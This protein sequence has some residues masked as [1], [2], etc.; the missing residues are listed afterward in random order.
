[1]LANKK[2]RR[3]LLRQRAVSNQKIGSFD[4]SFFYPFC[5]ISHPLL[6]LMLPVT[7]RRNP[8]PHPCRMR[9]TAGLLTYS[10]FAPRLPNLGLYPQS[11]AFVVLSLAGGIYSSEHCLGLGTC[12][13][14]A[15]KPAPPV[16]DVPHRVPSSIDHLRY[17]TADDAN[18]EKKFF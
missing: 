10:L 15:L 14:I 1:M 4:K 7:R 2:T 11:V 8:H 12:G 13:L 6:F 16:A 3:H 5:S 17:D 18:V 9:S